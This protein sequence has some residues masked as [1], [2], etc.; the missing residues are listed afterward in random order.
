M[1]NLAIDDEHDEIGEDWTSKLGVNLRYCVKV[2]KNTAFKQVQYALPLSGIFS[3]KYGSSELFNIK[4]KS[5]K[6]RSKG[7][8][9][10][11]SPS[12]PGEIVDMTVDKILVEK[13]DGSIAK[14]ERKIIQYSRKKRRKPAYC[15]EGGGGLELLKDDLPREDSAPTC[16]LLDEHGGCKSK[17][18][19][20]SE[21][22]RSSPA[23]LEIHNTSL[24]GVV[25]KD[26]NEILELSYLD[27]EACSL[28]TCA[29]SEKQCE[30]LMERTSENNDIAPADRYSKCCVVT[31]DERLAKNAA[32]VDDV[33]NPV[34]EGQCEKQVSSHDLINLAN[35]ASSHP[36]LPSSG[37][38]DPGLDAAVEKSCIIEVQQETEATRRNNNECILCDN[39]PNNLGLEDFSSAVSLGNEAQ[40]E[41]GTKGGSQFE[42]FLSSP[43]LTKGPS[44]VSVGNKSEIP[45]EPCVAADLCDGTISKIKAQKQESQIN[46]SKEELLSGSTTSAGTDQPTRLCVE[47]YSLSSKNPCA[48]EGT[49]VTLDVEVLQEI[50][51]TKRSSGDEVI[52]SSH[53]RTKEK[54]PTHTVMEACS[55]VQIESITKKCADT[56]ADDDRHEDDLIRDEQNEDESVSCCVTPIKETS[57]PIQKYSRARRESCAT[58]NVNDGGELCSIENR[59]LDSDVA[60]CSSSSMNGRKRKR[61]VE[62][63][64]EKLGGNGF[65]RS[66][67]EGLR[68]RAQKDSINGVNVGETSPEVVPTKESR[69]PSIRIQSKKTIKKGSYRCDLEGCRMSFETKE[70]L[71]LH[72]RNRCPYEGCGK[73][74]RSHKYAILHQRVHEDDRPLKCPW[75]G[76]SM[77]FK[78]AWARTEHIRVHTGERPYQC[79]VEGC[80]LSFRFVSDFSRHRRKTGHYTNP[81]V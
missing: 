73:K 15:A 6:S 30:Q 50:Q 17:I 18:N 1:I 68:P 46:A 76:C 9:N 57:I 22:A 61:E 31:Y 34:S 16:Q 23:Q 80:G 36:A 5:R 72:K 79:K 2:R 40:D 74:F 45:K 41:I 48:K 28:I 54:Q 37:R 70:E 13:L 38:F 67:C 52:A 3:D 4:W 11:P 58:V 49:D 63:T 78:W 21:F 39:K 77:S 65:I 47:E 27:G 33:S 19:A 26:Q 64:P 66:P 8:L 53:L 44:T 32:S 7:K 51:C 29:S 35:S 10:L 43:I 24:G 14:N 59:K 69:K 56:T 42:P 20:K 71:R 60:N 25:Q 81:S 12:K 75:K 62:E 55:E